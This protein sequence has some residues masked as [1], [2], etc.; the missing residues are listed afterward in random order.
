MTDDTVFLDD[1]FF[2][3]PIATSP[4]AHTGIR[5]RGPMTP[6]TAGT[7]TPHTPLDTIREADRSSGDA[8]AMSQ[9][10]MLRYRNHSLN[11]RMSVPPMFKFNLFLCTKMM[12][13]VFPAL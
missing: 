2:D 12:S 5:R 8:S 9:V 13:I 3:V 1:I 6:G 7:L 4:L 10:L 11:K